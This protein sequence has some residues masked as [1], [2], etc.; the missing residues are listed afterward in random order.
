MERTKRAWLPE[1]ARIVPIAFFTVVGQLLPLGLEGRYWALAANAVALVLGLVAMRWR[2]R[3]PVT[4]TVALSVLMLPFPS[5]WLVSG[6]AYLSLATHLRTRATVLVGLLVVVCFTLGTVV[7]SELPTPSDVAGAVVLSG[8]SVVALGALGSYLGSRR[9]EEAAIQARLELAER[10]QR[11]E[12]EN[13]KAEE[14]NRIAREMHDVLAHKI[15]L[16]SL[17][18]GALAYRDD[19]APDEVRQA[20][21]TI[22]AS[23]H[24]ALAELRMILGQ[25]RQT[26]GG[27]PAKPQPTLADL[28]A[29]VEGHREA[30]HQ[31]VLDDR[32]EAEPLQTVSRHAY[33]IA[34]EAL[35]NA[36]RHAPGTPVEIVIAGGPEM[37]LS[38]RISNPLSL[39]A[40]TSPG[41]GLGLVGLEERVDLAGGHM[42]A[43]EVDGHFVVDA[44][45]AWAPA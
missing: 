1:A 31:V 40:A 32:L 19:L 38:L 5:L 20:G 23:A 26:D 35:T 27:A 17:H 44:W 39:V 9:R 43:G 14:R 15:T 7:E 41:A 13:A 11:L 33:R 6:W 21:E 8:I 28:P 4:L 45:L 16:I 42:T 10:Q 36:A 22:R 12:R 18:A 30:G 2:R 3:H 37:G 29:L 25:L 34:Q 24:D